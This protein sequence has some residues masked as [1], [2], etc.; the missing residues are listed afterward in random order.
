[1]YT[2]REEREVR[3]VSDWL[4]ATYLEKLGA[5]SSAPQVWEG[6]GWRV[7][8]RPEPPVRVGSLHVGRVTL[9]M[10]ALDEPTFEAFFKR[11]DVMLMR[12]GG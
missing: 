4:I 2:Y 6:D 1:M 3:G 9:I 8:I 11:F 7:T 12:G 5:T 10:E